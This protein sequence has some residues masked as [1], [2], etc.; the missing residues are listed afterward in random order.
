MQSYK[1]SLTN[2]AH[3]QSL[4]KKN[5][6]TPEQLSLATQDVKLYDALI[7]PLIAKMFRDDQLTFDDIVQNNV[8]N[9]AHCVATLDEFLQLCSNGSEQVPDWFKS[10]LDARG[11]KIFVT[12]TEFGLDYESIK[13]NFS[14]AVRDFNTKFLEPRLAFGPKC[15]IFA[16][17][18][19]NQLLGYSVLKFNQQDVHLEHL[20]SVSS[21]SI[22]VEY[23]ETI[24]DE[25]ENKKRLN[26]FSYIGSFLFAAST[27]ACIKAKDCGKKLTWWSAK[28][29]IPFYDKFEKY[30]VRQLEPDG[31]DP[32][33]LYATKSINNAS[34]IVPKRDFFEKLPLNAPLS[35]KYKKP[36]SLQT[37]LDFNAVTESRKKL[38]QGV[39][40]V[41]TI[42]LI[43]NKDKY[44]SYLLYDKIGERKGGAD[45]RQD[46]RQAIIKKEID[47]N[48]YVY[49]YDPESKSL[50]FVYVQDGDVGRIREVGQK[51]Q[52]DSLDD[53]INELK[54]Q[55]SNAYEVL[56][57]QAVDVL[58]TKTNDYKSKYAWIN[59]MNNI[60]TNA[61]SLQKQD[62][63]DRQ[64]YHKNKF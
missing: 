37:I 59:E 42:P 33:I 55:E 24:Q 7:N 6:I 1:V 19:N 18:G 12:D 8:N 4:L 38:L 49:K 51:N 27:M 62:W 35:K 32:F 44:K 15:T 10:A 3:I 16:L 21:S 2:E 64:K 63:Q 60:A 34:D 26:M 39:G 14:F 5:I 54:L 9:F 11:I 45:W 25:K 22:A 23:L 61:M 56:N 40:V 50:L 43:K 28:D 41:T 46:I 31:Q 57:S 47:A 53:I 52:D 48:A 17:D 20:A 29:A 58:A 30:G 36:L 13:K